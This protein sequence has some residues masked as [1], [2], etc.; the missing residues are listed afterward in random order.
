[1]KEREIAQSERD[2]ARWR[3]E[4]G[5][6]RKDIQIWTSQ[7]EHLRR[8]L[9]E[10]DQLIYEFNAVIQTQQHEI[11]QHEDQM[12]VHDARRAPTTARLYQRWCQACAHV[13]EAES[14]GHLIAKLEHCG[15]QRM[16]DG[17]VSKIEAARAVLGA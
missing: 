1:M 2:H 14:E 13:H 7:H 5:H 8:I 6:W 10:V 4:H 17:I 9:D 11:V 16:H 3:S 15:L 12:L